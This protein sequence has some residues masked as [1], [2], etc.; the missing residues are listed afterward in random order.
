MTGGALGRPSPH[1]EGR[2]RWP[3]PCGDSLFD[4]LL[5]FRRWPSHVFSALAP[6]CFFGFWPPLYFHP[7]VLSASLHILSKSDFKHQGKLEH[8]HRE[9]VAPV[10][11]CRVASAANSL[12]RQLAAQA[13]AEKQEEAAFQTWWRENHVLSVTQSSASR[14]TGQ[15]R[16]VRSRIMARGT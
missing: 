14:V 15:D 10:N 8:V 3:P 4:H 6:P 5:C 1:G 2:L 16:P 9:P 13:E 12:A 7:L 11:N